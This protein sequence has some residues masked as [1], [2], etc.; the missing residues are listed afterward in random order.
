DIELD[1]LKHS[2]T[3][4]NSVLSDLEDE[5]DI[6]FLDCPPGITLLSENIFNSSDIILVPVI[7]TTLSVRTYLMLLQ[8]FKKHKLDQSK[9]HP[10]FSM[11]EIRKSMH[12]DAISNM[13]S[14]I[15][16]FLGAQI[17]YRSNVEKMGVYRMPLNDFEPFS[18]AAFAYSV[19]WKEVQQI[20]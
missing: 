18:P 10:F 14:N 16:N 11:V 15:T 17:P 5:Y 2:K 4:F 9:I 20:N 3:Q 19:L 7:P 8:F 13:K 12:Q 6:I 1:S